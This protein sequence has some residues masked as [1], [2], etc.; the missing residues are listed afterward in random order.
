MFSYHK[1]KSHDCFTEGKNPLKADFRFPSKRILQQLLCNT[2]ISHVWETVETM[3]YRLSHCHTRTT[4]HSEF[5]QMFCFD[6]E[7]IIHLFLPLSQEEIPFGSNLLAGH[8]NESQIWS[9][10]LWLENALS[11]A[12][13]F[14]S[15]LGLCL[16]SQCSGPWNKVYCLFVCLNHGSVFSYGHWFMW[17]LISWKGLTIQGHNVLYALFFEI[18]GE[19]CYKIDGVIFNNL[20]SDSCPLRNGS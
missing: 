19:I 3:I 7:N 17:I 16:L 10:A 8:G 13:R 9:M 2:I 20:D 5:Q 12:G 14:T 4:N 1:W 15:C 6:N 18:K 11:E